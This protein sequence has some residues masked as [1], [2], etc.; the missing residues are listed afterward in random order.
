MGVRC[1]FVCLC[2]WVGVDMM[3]GHCVCVC[4]TVYGSVCG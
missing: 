4:A 3:R 1:G 2:E